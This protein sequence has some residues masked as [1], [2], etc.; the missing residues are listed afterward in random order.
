MRSASTTL[1]AFS[2]AAF[3]SLATASEPAAAKIELKTLEQ[4]TSYTLGANLAENLKKQGLKVDIQAFAMGLDDALNNHPP[5]LSKEEMT[6][7][8][9][10]TKKIMLEKQAAEKT[11]QIKENQAEG[12]AFAA[13]YAKES[14][15]KK[16][17][18]GI[19]YKVQESGDAAG[20]SPGDEDT[21]FA[22]YEGRFIDGKIFDSSYKRG[23]PLKLK[24]NNVIKGWGEILKMMKPGD[25]WE[26]MIPP[27]MAYG[28]RGAGDIIG[29]DKT[30]IFTIELISFNKNDS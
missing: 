29:P 17:A 4:K 5:A 18:N 7:A 16:A 30:L 2:L 10:E 15:V 19:L 26:V 23:S 6:Q 27:E 20:A 12:K 22:H 11:A 24:T 8:V 14:G 13:K 28:S 9:T 21:I 3:S 25:K 1:L